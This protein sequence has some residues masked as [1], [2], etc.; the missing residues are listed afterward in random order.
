MGTFII[1]LAAT[2]TTLTVAATTL[3]APPGTQLQGIPGPQNGQMII[4]QVAANGL[5]S[6][7]VYQD[8]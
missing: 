2:P 3:A 5:P 1:A 7:A 6:L 4:G 8:S